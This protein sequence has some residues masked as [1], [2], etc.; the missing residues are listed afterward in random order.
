M[1]YGMYVHR[2]LCVCK[3]LYVRTMS[4]AGAVC[5]SERTLVILTTMAKDEDVCAREFA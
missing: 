5:F 4:Y 1:I 3:V 2:V